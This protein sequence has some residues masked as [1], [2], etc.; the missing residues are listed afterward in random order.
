MSVVH[1][2]DRSELPAPSVE[3]V[4]HGIF[5]YIQ[6]D[7]SWFLNNTGFITSPDGVIVVDSTGTEARAK[8]FHAAV[9]HQTDLPLRALVN[10]HSHGD[11]TFGN[12]VFTPDCAIIGHELCREAV[13]ATDVEATTRNF[14]NGDFGEITVAAPFVTF[15]QRL[16]VYAD[17]LQVQLIHMGP[18]H[19]PNDVVAWI[20]E[21]RLLFTGD[22]IFNQ[23]TPFALQGSIAG[24]LEALDRIEALDAQTIVPGHG[25]VGGPELIDPVRRYLR[26]IEGVARDGFAA[27]AA[28]RDLARD[29]DL[30]EFADLHDPER[31]VPNLHRA[32]SELRGEARAAP[33]AGA[34]MFAE[35]IEYNG[36]EPLRCLA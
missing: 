15:E 30:G 8:A 26:F 18:A 3:E 5:A 23:G 25:P 33:L 35:M 20:P 4:S 10:T 27:D 28:P 17:D 9:R 13:L 29:L 16:N 34:Q 21:R 1:A 32:Y 7:G 24:W 19:T 12:F 36:G 22:L 6:L 31:L 14:V 11:H 2:H